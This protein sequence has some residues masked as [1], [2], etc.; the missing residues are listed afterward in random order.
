MKLNVEKFGLE[1]F[2]SGSSLEG[3][4]YEEV[5]EM[6]S[7]TFKSGDEEFTISQAFTLDI[8]NILKDKDNYLMEMD[9]LM[10]E[11][12]VKRF[13]FAVTDIIKN[14]SYILYD[15][16]SEDVVKKAFNIKKVE[17]GVFLKDV[18]SRKQQIVP[19]VLD[20]ID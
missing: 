6:D 14:G 4:T 19:A 16:K 11:T 17:E 2:K 12:G 13:I 15:S 5:L 20:A 7:K 18:V 3:M 10:K 8:D 1:M 9:K